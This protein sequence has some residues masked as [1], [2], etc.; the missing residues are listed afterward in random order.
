VGRLYIS[1]VQFKLLFSGHPF[2]G[3]TV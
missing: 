3:T 2:E 1:E